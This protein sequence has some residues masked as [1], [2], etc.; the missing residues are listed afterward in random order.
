MG[1][2]PA[3]LP[4]TH[5]TTDTTAHT[6]APHLSDEALHPV[7][8]HVCALNQIAAAREEGGGKGDQTSQIRLAQRR[9]VVSVLWSGEPTLPWQGLPGKPPEGPTNTAP[10]LTPAL[11]PCWAAAA[12]R[13]A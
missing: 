12:C 4:V 3:A 5:P 13:C 9:R 11:T 1:S 2:T 8:V 7:Q 6:L 10:P